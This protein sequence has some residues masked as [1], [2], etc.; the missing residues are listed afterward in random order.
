MIERDRD[1]DIPKFFR[2]DSAFA[3]PKL[4]AVLEGNGFRYAIRLKSNPVLDRK[5]GHGLTR[6]VGRPSGKP[7]FVDHRFRYRAGSWDRDRRVVAQIAWR[8]G[9]LFARVGFV[10]TN[11]NWRSRRVVRFYNKRGTGEQ[12]IEEG[13]NAVNGTELSCRRF[14]NNAARLQLFAPAYNLANFVR[15]LALPKPIRSRTPTTLREKPVKIGPRWS[16]TRSTSPFSWR[17]WRC[18][19]R[20][21]RRS[22]PRIVRPKTVRP[23]ARLC[24]LLVRRGILG[25]R[26][27]HDPPGPSGQRGW[28]AR[29][30]GCPGR[31]DRRVRFTVSEQGG[32]DGPARH[33]RVRRARAD[34]SRV[35]SG[36]T[37]TGD[38]A[39]GGAT[40]RVLPGRLTLR[41]VV[42]DEVVPDSSFP[43]ALRAECGCHKSGFTWFPRGS[44]RHSSGAT[45]RT[46]QNPR[47]FQSSV[48]RVG[49]RTQVWRSSRGRLR[50]TRCR[51]ATRRYRRRY[52]A[53]IIHLR[54]R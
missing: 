49:R 15:Q 26:V 40:S 44:V 20:C 52:F 42:V 50:A 37:R 11:L 9:E 41:P 4:F 29:L 33:T 10:V 22:G 17:K 18:R 1:R 12:W 46:R 39:R 16:G 32:A 21:S 34:P 13:T 8:A 38:G 47:V 3:F 28:R 14:R 31:V 45:R 25:V 2:G 36:R 30:R 43:A 48:G 35:P 7:K 24:G 23:L 27:G 5:I 54:G 6:P 19:G 51:T 53:R